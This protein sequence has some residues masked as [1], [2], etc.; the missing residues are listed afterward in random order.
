MADPSTSELST[1]LQENASRGLGS[2][3]ELRARELIRDPVFSGAPCWLC[4]MEGKTVPSI[5]DTHL[6]QADARYVLATGK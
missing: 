6:C 2:E 4:R 5:Y 1:L 3:D